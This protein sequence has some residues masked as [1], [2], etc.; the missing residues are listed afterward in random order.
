[1]RRSAFVVLAGWVSI[2]A[3][4]YGQF[5]GNLEL[6]P[7]GCAVAGGTCTVVKDFGFIDPSGVGWQAKAGLETDGATIPVWAQPF[8]GGQFDTAFIRAAVIHDHYC[9]RRV[10][11]FLSTHRVFYDALI[12]S[13]VDAVKANVMYYA[14]LVGGPKW[15]ELI[16]GEQCNLGG[17]CIRSAGGI[18]N[19]PDSKVVIG[20]A[21]NRYLWRDRIYSRSDV[22]KEIREGAKEIERQNLRDPADA[23]RL[24]RERRP[25][26]QFLYLREAALYEEAPATP[27][28]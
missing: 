9:K 23:L 27:N 1:M 3:P 5:I 10:R 17:S 4:A 25:G 15:I 14:V 16:P 22:Q 8:V 19:I 2:S 24:A 6:A 13:G 26:D 11:G 28:R 21:G 18:L 7:Q 12:E 20:E